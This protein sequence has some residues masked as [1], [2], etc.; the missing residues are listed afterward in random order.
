MQVISNARNLARVLGARTVLFISNQRFSSSLIQSHRSFL[1]CQLYGEASS[2]M[3]GSCYYLMPLH[4]V[5]PMISRTSFSTEAGTTDNNPTEAVKELYDNMLQSVNVKRTMPPNASLWSMIGNC[6]NHGDIKLLFDVLQNLRRFR[7]SN[8]HIHSNFNCN[9]CQEVA[10]ACALVGAIDFGKKA[11]CLHNVYGLTPSIASAHHLLSYAKVHNDAKL[12]VEVMRL[13]KRNNLPLQAGTADIVFSICSNTNIW[14]LISK[15]SKRFIKASV[16]LRQTT[17]DAWMEFAARRGDT[18]SLWN[19]EKLRSET[20]KQHSLTTGFACAKG[21]LLERKPEDAA[22]LIQVLN[23]TL[24][25]AKKPGITVEVEKLVN[26]WPSEV[27]KH[28]KE[29][30]RKALAAALKSDI[31]TMV[32]SLLNIGLARSVNM[33][34]LTKKEILS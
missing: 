13:L 5:Y 19:I 12:M 7:L 20:M 3:C 8:L 2:G 11:L 25:D 4:S 33:E 29:E 28:Q 26:E 6:K 14:E 21:L 9:L 31:S 23:G 10:R 15:Y 32:A 17:F 1:Q 18:D 34:D 22:A 30:D 24:S 27:L 16:K